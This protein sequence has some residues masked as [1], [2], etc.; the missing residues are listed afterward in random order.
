MADDILLT[1]EELDEKAKQWLKDNGVALVVGIALGLG[2]IFGFNA[3]KDSKQANAEEASSLYSFVMDQVT[4][5]NTINIDEPVNSLKTDHVGTPYA[6]KAVLIKAGQ[7]AKTDV[8]ASLVEYQWVIDNAKEVGLRHTAKI[9]K[10]K[11]YVSLSEYDKAKEIASQ[12]PYDN[13]ASHYNEILGDVAVGQAELEMAYG[14]YQQATEQLLPGDA[15]YASVLQLKM[16]PLPK[17]EEEVIDS[18]VSNT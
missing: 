8:P 14:Y 15:S 6:A 13:F 16:A 4:T 18:L 7:L 3:Y 11:L 17:P 1:Q 2:G 12:E 5:S 10:A 9:R